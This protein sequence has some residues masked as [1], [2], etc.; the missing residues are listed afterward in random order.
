MELPQVDQDR[1][2]EP[3]HSIQ[4]QPGWGPP[5]FFEMESAIPEAIPKMNRSFMAT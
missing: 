1:V 4:S 3:F 2:R 5:V